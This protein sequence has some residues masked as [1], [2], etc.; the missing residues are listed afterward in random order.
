MR[1]GDGFPLLLLTYPRGKTAVADKI[2]SILGRRL[3]RLPGRILAAYADT[4][5]ALPAMVVVILR[6]HN[7]C[8]CLGHYHP[9]G[10]ESRLAKRLA[11]DLGS[12]VGE[13]DLAYE[14]IRKWEPHPISAL[15]AGD[16]GGLLPTI[17]YEA[18]LMGVFL[19]ELQHLAFP[20]RQE[21]SVRGASDD[22]YTS[23]M[24]ELVAREG[25]ATYGM[26]VKV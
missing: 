11:S 14:A 9:R 16:L 10:T 12:P 19:H 15:A 1:P 7:A 4:L 2:G 18:A 21:R 22:F 8:G 25:G 17:H 23:L 3:P 6:P 24:Q 5:A 26:N 20:D 13:I